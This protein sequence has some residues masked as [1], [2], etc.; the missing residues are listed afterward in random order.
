MNVSSYHVSCE[1]IGTDGGDVRQSFNIINCIRALCELLSLNSTKYQLNV[2][3]FFRLIQAR[4]AEKCFRF[5]KANEMVQLEQF[6][7]DARYIG[8]TQRWSRYFN[9]VE[10]CPAYPASH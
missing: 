5:S 8:A 3:H 9:G 10:L 2:H 1:A 7:T 4:F 6:Y